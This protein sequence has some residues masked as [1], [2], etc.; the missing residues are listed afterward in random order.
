MVWGGIWAFLFLVPIRKLSCYSRG[1]WYSLPQT[2]IA[3]VVLFPQM[4][5]G[6]LGLKLGYSTPLLILFFGVVWGITT[7]LWLK[8]ARGHG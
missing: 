8:L 6:M 2:L 3:L 5:R 1:V 7:A 4:N